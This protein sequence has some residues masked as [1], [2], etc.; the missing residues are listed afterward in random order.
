VASADAPSEQQNEEIQAQQRND[1]L[2]RILNNSYA[3]VQ[4]EQNTQA[5]SALTYEE[6]ADQQIEAIEGAGTEARPTELERL[7]K[8]EDAFLSIVSEIKAADPSQF[9]LRNQNTD[10]N[11]PV[12][13]EP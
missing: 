13:P 2:R 7:D 9:I 11:T 8:M 12:E 10:V 4:G 3:F 6:L 1:E 5:F